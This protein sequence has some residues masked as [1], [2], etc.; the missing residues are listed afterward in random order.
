MADLRE[1]TPSASQQKKKDFFYKLS[2][3]QRRTM[4]Q[5]LKKVTTIDETRD[6][7][8]GA[9]FKRFVALEE[10][11]IK[12][13]SYCC[14]PPQF[15]I[16]VYPTRAPLLFPFQPRRP[17]PLSPPGVHLSNRDHL[18][19]DLL[20]ASRNL[21]ACSAAQTDLFN[22]QAAMADNLS[23]FYDV[24]SALQPVSG[25]N[26]ESKTYMVTQVTAFPHKTRPRSRLTSFRVVVGIRSRLC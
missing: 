17:I 10:R 24:P 11:T 13:I 16:P 23:E 21:Q 20:L 9:L 18:S 26:K 25:L 19:A 14:P 4:H 2:A 6:E 7:E 1:A 3:L 8:Y 22:A 15:Q 5:V 12:L